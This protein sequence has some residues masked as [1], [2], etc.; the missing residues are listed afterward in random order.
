[1]SQYTLAQQGDAEALAALTRRHLPL[2]HALSRRFPDREDA[3]QQGCLGLVKAIRGFREETGCQFSTYAVPVILGEMRRTRQ[4]PLG[5]R[6][7]AALRRARAFREDS[8]R[9]TGRE[10]GMTEI[11]RA[12]GVEPAELALLL[13]RDRKPVYDASGDLLPS[14]PDPRGESWLLRLMIRD[15]ME[16]LPGEETWL[17][18]QRFLL[19]NSQTQLARTLGVSQSQLSRREK[20]ARERFCRAWLQEES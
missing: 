4:D 10:P 2:V 20:R 13:E 12:A 5:W 3:F 8:L 17:L 14:L 11:A 1:M 7:R 18:R 9:C 19:G 16:R 15:V 6:S